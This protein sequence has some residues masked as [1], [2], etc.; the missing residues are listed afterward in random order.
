[1][2]AWRAGFTVFWPELLCMAWLGTGSGLVSLGL[3]GIQAKWVTSL[4]E[5]RAFS[6]EI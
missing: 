4:S 3:F 6:S 1:M 2:P 5:K